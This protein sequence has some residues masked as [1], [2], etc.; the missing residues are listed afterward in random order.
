VEKEKKKGDNGMVKKGA[1]RDPN[2]LAKKKN[3]REIAAKKKY[4]K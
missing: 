3:T 1:Q 2:L 4:Y